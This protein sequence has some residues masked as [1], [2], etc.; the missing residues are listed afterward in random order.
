[1][2]TAPPKDFG[3]FWHRAGVRVAAMFVVFIVVGAIVG[4][5]WSWLLAPSAGWIAAAATFSLWAG[6][7]VSRL[8]ADETP[9]HA[10]REDPTQPVAQALLVLASIASFGAIGLLL[11]E[12][13]SASGDT[14]LV[15][16]AAALATVTAS[17]LLIQV[18]FTLRYAA[19]YYRA[20][21]TGI[22]FNQS[23]PPR[24]ADFAYLAFTLGM[25]YQVSDTDL[26]SSVMRAEVLKH[27]LLS[28][29]FGVGVLATTINLV[30]SIAG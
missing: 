4:V 14:T 12:A 22:D 10:T 2:T 9:L 17:W 19:L 27:S 30:T 7:V 8:G 6:I 16:A 1:M 11:F 21:G 18:L 13:R 26:T 3:G 25:T 5:S 29:V 23:E 15:F 24:Y 28:F 20:G